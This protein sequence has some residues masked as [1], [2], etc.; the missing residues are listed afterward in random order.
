VTEKDDPRRGFESG[1]LG[2]ELVVAWIYLAIM[3]ASA[4]PTPLYPL[5]RQRLE[6][7]ASGITAVYGFYA[8][9]VLVTLLRLGSLADRIGRRPV[10]TAAVAITVLSELVLAVSPTLPGLYL[11]RGLVAV[12]VGLAIAALPAFLADLGGPGHAARATVLAVAANMGGQALGTFAAGAIPGSEPLVTPYLIGLGLLA[13]TVLLWTTRVPETLPALRGPRAGRPPVKR[14][15]AALRA[16]YRAIAMTIVGAFAMFGSMTAMTGQILQQRMLIT[17]TSTTGLV[18]AAMF[19]SGAAGQLLARRITTARNPAVMVV[20][21]PLAALLLG[22]ATLAGSLPVFAVA[23]SVCGFAGGS[24]LRAG[25]IRVLALSPVENRAHVS[26]RLFAALYLGASVCTVSAGLLATEVSLDVAVLGLGSLV[27]V[28]SAG[29]ALLLNRLPGTGEA[30][31]TTDVLDLTGFSPAESTVQFFAVPAVRPF[32][33]DALEFP[34][35]RGR[36]TGLEKL[37]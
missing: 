36:L 20:P 3:A 37:R 10:L 15:P 12:A 17:G 7:P 2:H 29:A 5:Y 11:G 19:A 1:R 6:L 21:L 26:S 23:V 27:L 4:L 25:S 24:C 9:V 33:S 18:T 13:P 30:L 32:R 28:L 16:D 22:W 14:I 31:A 35:S 34:P 8:V